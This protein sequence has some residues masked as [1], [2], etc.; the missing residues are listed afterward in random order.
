MSTVT[1][2]GRRNTY[3]DSMHH[4]N[5]SHSSPGEAPPGAGQRA[6]DGSE[7]QR[8]EEGVKGEVEQSLHPIIAQT[9]QRVDVVLEKTQN[10]SRSMLGN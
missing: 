10:M 5:S 4:T 3:S 1:T 2:D 7:G 6:E 8:R 9:F